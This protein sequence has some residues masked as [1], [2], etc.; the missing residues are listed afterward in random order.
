MFEYLQQ[1]FVINNSWYSCTLVICHKK[2]I[3]NQFP[4]T[5]INSFDNITLILR[6][7]VTM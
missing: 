5:S 6:K 3:Y 7:S 4:N 1:N 2:K